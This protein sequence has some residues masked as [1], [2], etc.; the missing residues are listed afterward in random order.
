MAYVSFTVS[1]LCGMLSLLSATRVIKSVFAVFIA[2]SIICASG[3]LTASKDRLVKIEK[4]SYSAGYNFS[5][6]PVQ[7]MF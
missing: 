6:I 3:S 7:H 5:F 1:L 4:Q 2:S